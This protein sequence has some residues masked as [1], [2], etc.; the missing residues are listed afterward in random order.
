M[1]I[2][3]DPTAADVSFDEWQDDVS[4]TFVPLQAR[5]LDDAQVGAFHGHVRSAPLGTVILSDVAA[6]SAV[7]ERTPRLIRQDDPEFYKFGLQLRGE[8][9]IEQDGRQ[10]HLRPGDFA[11]YD[12]SRPYRLALQ[13]DFEMRIAMFPRNLVSL[14][15][16]HLRTLTAVRLAGDTGLASLL[17]PL[18]R[19]LSAQTRTA[20]G[21]I[22]THLGDAVVDLVTAAFAEQLAVTLPDPAGAGRRALVERTYQF[23]DRHLADPDLNTA[24]IAAA[25]FVSV[26]HLQKA[27]EMQGESVSAVVR[28]RRLERC[29]RDLSDPA[30][31][32]RPVAVI[33]ARWG[34]LDASHFSRLFS[35]TFGVSPRR[36]RERVT[37]RS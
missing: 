19:G 5:S 16:E 34:L 27:F 9:V 11:I 36:Y 13:H 4:R 17:S 26:R 1:P 12:T 10:A 29:R 24:T 23:I 35:S 2:T 7:V 8:C 18:M 25:Q 28:S 30:L 14:P 3:C 21:Q 33:G 6:S 15:E 31:A 20:G 32:D 37:T 22:A